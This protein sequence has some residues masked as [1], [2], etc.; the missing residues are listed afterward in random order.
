MSDIKFFDDSNLDRVLE[1]Q[2]RETLSA[3]DKSF[4][5]EVFKGLVKWVK[6]HAANIEF[7]GGIKYEHK[8]AV[9]GFD[10]KSAK[11][12]LSSFFK[13][14][15][16]RIVPK[17]DTSNGRVAVVVEYRKGGKLKIGELSLTRNPKT[18][19]LE[20]T[21]ASLEEFKKVLKEQNWHKESN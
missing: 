2:G 7:T 12:L 13:K 8:N 9:I 3:D 4:F 16:F 19:E 20:V 15:E 11:D 14:G 6:E 18:N 10:F 1:M 17:V 5:K 21:P